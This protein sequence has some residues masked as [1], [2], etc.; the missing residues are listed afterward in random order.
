[1]A[2][3]DYLIEYALLLKL[4]AREM[5]L[6][7]K[8]VI[9]TGA[10]SG[11]GQS[12]ASQLVSEGAFVV[13]SAREDEHWTSMQTLCEEDLSNRLL[14]H[15]ADMSDFVQLD[16]LF[17]FT[18]EKLKR[19][20]LLINNAGYGL[21]GPIGAIDVGEFEH[22]LKV[23]VV[24]PLHLTQRILAHM[25]EKG[26]KGMIVNVSSLVS[27]RPLPFTGAYC[28]SKAALT[29]LTKAFRVEATNV[30]VML[31]MPGLTRTNFRASVVGIENVPIELNSGDKLAVSPETVAQK[32]I[33]GIKREK[34]E[35][36]ITFYDVLYA[37]LNCLFERP[38]EKLLRWLLK[39]R[40]RGQTKQLVS[41]SKMR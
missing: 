6:K 9:V 35:V 16:K 15:K 2:L 39:N 19:I 14:C 11:I 40:L 31:V 20:D 27:I 1:M 23:N 24:G 5:E 34:H 29:A 30:H 33:K 8:V 37:R 28:A 21:Y 3:L 25:Q 12:L 4:E 22:Q 13:A 7:D 10:S 17:E 32:I 18:I 26:H 41:P 36:F 38:I